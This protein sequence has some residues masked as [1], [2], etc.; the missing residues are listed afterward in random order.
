MT[1]GAGVG[2]NFRAKTPV[3]HVAMRTFTAIVISFVSF[4]QPVDAGSQR[5]G[6]P[7]FPR[8]LTPPYMAQTTAVLTLFRRPTVTYA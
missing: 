6:I 8:S 3:G 7:P 5:Q 1:P 2:S 4:L